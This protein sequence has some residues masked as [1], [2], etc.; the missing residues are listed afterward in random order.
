MAVAVVPRSATPPRTRVRGI[1]GAR[2]R[3]PTIPAEY[4]PSRGRSPSPDDLERER[5][6]NSVLNTPEAQRLRQLRE[7][8]ERLTSP[9]AIEPPALPPRLSLLPRQEQPG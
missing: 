8:G 5:L 4:R 1:I 7:D 6:R 9:L 3:T 2:R